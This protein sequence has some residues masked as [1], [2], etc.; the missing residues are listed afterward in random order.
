MCSIQSFYI[1][2]PH[3]PGPWTQDRKPRTLDSGLCSQEVVS[4]WQVAL[5]KQGLRDKLRTALGMKGKLDM[6][7]AAV[8]E[9]SSKQ[10]EL[11]QSAV[12]ALSDIVSPSKK[13]SSAE[14]AVSAL[15]EIISP[16]KKKSSAE[17]KSEGD[18]CALPT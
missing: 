16:S 13:K 3:D 4:A 15:S 6:W 12:S 2:K 7:K 18:S 5:G 17:A 8:A 1:K 14:S 10:K 9:V 11:G